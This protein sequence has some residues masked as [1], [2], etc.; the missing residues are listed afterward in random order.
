MRNFLLSVFIVGLFS[1]TAAPAQTYFNLHQTF[2]VVNHNPNADFGSIKPVDAATAQKAF[3]YIAQKAKTQFNYPQGG[4]PERAMTMHFLLDSLKVPNVRIWIF[5]PS[6]LVKGSTTKLFIYDKNKLTT[7]KDN[8]IEWDFHVAPAILVANNGK[9]DTLVVDPSINSTAALPYKAW[10]AAI[11]GHEKARYTFTDGKY[12]SFNRAEGG[13]S[14]VISGEFYP[15]EGL[16]YGNLW[17]EKM[18]A[19]NDTAYAMYLKY[20]KDKDPNAQATKDFR[21][22][23]GN[24][25]TLKEVLDYKDGVPE[26]AKIRTLATKYPEFIQTAW[27]TYH[28]QLFFWTLRLHKLKA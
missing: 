7:D 8:K 17:L 10:M 18:M 26:A 27:K 5:A 4:C 28:S 9:T 15:Y 14:N 1:S 3:T 23:I 21:A 19:M 22:V 24:S 25:A 12:Y 2:P 13:N 11:N 16:S 6:R 20:I